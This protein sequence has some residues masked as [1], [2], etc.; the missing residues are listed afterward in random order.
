MQNDR[1]TKNESAVPSYRKGEFFKALS[2][3][4]QADLDALLI[5][6]NY[7]AGVS[8]FIESQPATGIYLVLEGEVKLS[9]NSADGH[10]LAIHVA[11]AGEVLGLSSALSGGTYEMTAD[12][13]Y[14]AKV[15]HISRQTLLQF[16]AQHTE[17]YPIV[18][19]EIAR[20]FNLACD[21]LRL[22]GTSNSAPHRLARLLLVWSENAD[23]KSENGS[24]CRL[25]MTHE[26]IG[27]FIGATRETVS[28][29]MMVFKNQ[30]LVA[31]HGCMLTIPSPS[32]LENYA[33]K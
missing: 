4:A 25:S 28:R 7:P 32:A 5:P 12:T 9:M 15:A 17:V 18:S 19:R 27:Q 22:L 26:E 31:Q 2:T 6:S 11:K 13:L 3:T 23:Q 29:T 24:R 16:L 30:Q 14:P 1:E 8:L 21:Q 20:S 33:R 10:R